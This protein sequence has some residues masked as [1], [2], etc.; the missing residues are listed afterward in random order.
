MAVNL[1]NVLFDSGVLPSERFDI[2]VICVGNITAGGTGKTPHTEYLIRLLAAQNQV[3]VLSR[4]YKR[5]SKGYILARDN[6][7]MKMIGDEPYQMKH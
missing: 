4:G 6:M 3:A 1:R 7:P 2:P 5:K